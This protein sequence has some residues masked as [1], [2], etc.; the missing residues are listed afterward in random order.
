MTVREAVCLQII[1]I[2]WLADMVIDNSNLVVPET[3]F[4]DEILLACT[5][6]TEKFE[7]FISRHL[8]DCEGFELPDKDRC[9]PYSSPRKGLGEDCL[10]R[11]AISIDM[12]NNGY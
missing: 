3:R 10:A 2:A 8:P 11:D 12:G 9:C 1:D 5:E 7:R 4:S 6:I